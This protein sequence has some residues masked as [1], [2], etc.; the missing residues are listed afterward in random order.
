MNAKKTGAE[1]FVDDVGL[2]EIPMDQDDG[3]RR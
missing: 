1:L 3:T 2:I